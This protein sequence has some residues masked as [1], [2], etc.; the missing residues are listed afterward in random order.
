[1]RCVAHPRVGY[2]GHALGRELHPLP[3]AGQ[4]QTL[5]SQ[6]DLHAPR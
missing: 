4:I 1:M 2:T 5:R 3:C 6:K